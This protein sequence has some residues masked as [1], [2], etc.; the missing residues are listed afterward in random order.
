MRLCRTFGTE[1]S[2]ARADTGR[3]RSV[4]CLRDAEV[5]ALCPRSFHP[6]ATARWFRFRVCFE[7]DDGASRYRTI[8][9][10]LLGRLLAIAESQGLSSVRAP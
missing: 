3:H 6:N 4:I 2:D 8:T 5:P 9:R 10:A 7:V 1:G